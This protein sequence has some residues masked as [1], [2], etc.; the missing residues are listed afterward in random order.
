MTDGQREKDEIDHPPEKT[1][2]RSADITY[3]ISSYD[4]LLMKSLSGFEFLQRAFVWSL[5][6]NIISVS[7]NMTVFRKSFR[8][9]FIQCL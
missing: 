2:Q 7:K 1:L 4:I 5:P 3:S 8:S 6:E 9:H